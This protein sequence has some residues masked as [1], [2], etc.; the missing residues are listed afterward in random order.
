MRQRERDAYSQ[1]ANDKA[2]HRDGQ[3][4]IQTQTVREIEIERQS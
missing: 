4:E 2:V 1:T 3:A